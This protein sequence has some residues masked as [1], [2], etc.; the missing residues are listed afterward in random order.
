VKRERETGKQTGV[1]VTFRVVPVLW[2]TKPNKC[3]SY[4]DN[5]VTECT[6]PGIIIFLSLSFGDD[7]NKSTVYTSLI[8]LRSI[9]R[10]HCIRHRAVQN[11]T[12]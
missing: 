9:L 4:C 5:E 2:A 3:L 11:D 7:R 1:E 12:I 8:H 10:I 6:D